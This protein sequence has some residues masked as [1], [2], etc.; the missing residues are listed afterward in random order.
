MLTVDCEAGTVVD[1]VVDLAE[2]G[3]MLDVTPVPFVTT[4]SSNQIVPLVGEPLFTFCMVI[5][6]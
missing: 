1:E 5:T 3:F 6:N 2:I 4:N